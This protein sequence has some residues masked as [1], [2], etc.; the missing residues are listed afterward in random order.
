MTMKI[1]KIIL[2]GI[3]IYKNCKNQIKKAILSK[4]NFNLIKKK[5]IIYK[6]DN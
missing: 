1:K 3:F 2:I 5:L 4:K 6:K